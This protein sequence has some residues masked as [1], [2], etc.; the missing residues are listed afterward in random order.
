MAMVALQGR[1]V[2]TMPRLQITTRLTALAMAVAMVLL[3]LP[4]PVQAAANL[5]FSPSSASLSVGATWQTTVQVSSDSPVNSI[6]SYVNYPAD[7]LEV[8]SVD[9][10]N[11]VFSIVLFQPKVEGGRIHFVQTSPSPF[12]GSGGKIGTINFKVKSI[13]SGSLSFGTSKVIAQ[14]GKGTNVYSG[15]GSAY[16]TVAAPPPAATRTPTI[17]SSTHSNQQGWYKDRTVTYSWSGGASGYNYAVDQ[18]AGTQLPETQIGTVTTASTTLTSDGVWYAHVRAKGTNGWS[19]TAHFRIQVDSVA[20]A[21][22]T[23]TT[24]PEGELT[25]LPTLKYA[26]TD[27]GSGIDRYEVQMD[28]GGWSR[29]DSPYKVS[30]LTSGQHTAT[31][32]A[33]DKAGNTVDAQAHFT[34]KQLEAPV[35]TSPQDKQLLMLGEELK[36]KGLATPHA[37]VEIYINDK[38]VETI[39]ADEEG[40]FSSTQPLLL[41]AGAYSIVAKA[42]NDDGISSPPSAPVSLTIDARAVKLFGSVWPGWVVLIGALILFGMMAAGLGILAFKLRQLAHRWAAKL[43]NM[44]T[45]VD[46]DLGQLEQQVDA[47]IDANIGVGTPAA[48]AVKA[49]LAAEVQRVEADLDKLVAEQT[50]PP[51]EAEQQHPP[52]TDQL[53]AKLAPLMPHVTFGTVIQPTQATLDHLAQDQAAPPATAATNGDQATPAVAAPSPT[54]PVLAP[55]SSPPPA[56]VSAAPLPPPLPVGI[57]PAPVVATPTPVAPA[58][59]VVLQPVS[60]PSTQTDTVEPATALTAPAPAF[61]IDATP[62]VTPVPVAPAKQVVLPT[63]LPTTAPTAPP[64]VT[65]PPSAPA[66]TGQ[67]ATSP[68]ATDGQSALAAVQALD[69]QKPT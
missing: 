30:A 18:S 65:S 56:P 13:G 61:S 19:N 32:R 15:G 48:G 7:I 41:F 26:T 22:F 16:V 68:T 29:Q 17:S 4:T 62:V 28:G 3:M 42:V 57:M 23:V 47:S 21:G 8:T 67:S 69:G 38:K 14:D 5:S 33:F 43:R 60:T 24:E 1:E 44:D 6:D 12:S 64:P 31:V 58:N 49:A 52:I 51:T 11:S 39:K 45:S 46:Q 2:V 59:Q 37:T 27:T 36:V 35:I 54:E 10:S 9:T 25:V 53:K 63:S 50:P 55:V 66:P 20:P 40:N 34:L